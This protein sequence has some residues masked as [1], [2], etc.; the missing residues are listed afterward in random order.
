LVAKDFPELAC[1]VSLVAETPLVDP[2][3]TSIA[4]PIPLQKCAVEVMPTIIE[5]M[6]NHGISNPQNALVGKEIAR[7]AS[8]D[9]GN[10]KFRGAMAALTRAKFV[11]KTKGK[12]GVYLSPLG[13]GFYEQRKKSH[14]EI[15]QSQSSL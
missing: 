4:L 2:F 6:A 12:C 5:A 8:L 14:D 13:L 7:L 1:V 10:G 11:Y 15:D 9:Y 3:G